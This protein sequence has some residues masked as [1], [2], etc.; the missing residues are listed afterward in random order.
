MH[1]FFVS[2]DCIGGEVVT[3]TGDVAHQLT[4]VL[5][6]HSGDHIVV[7]DNSGLEYVVSQARFLPMIPAPTFRW[8]WTGRSVRLAAVRNPDHGA[9]RT[10]E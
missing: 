7:L 8:C 10:R 6:V 2:P 5:R 9:T 3:L 1:R 4:R